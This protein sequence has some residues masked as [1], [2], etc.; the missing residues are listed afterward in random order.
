[1]RFLAVV[2]SCDRGKTKPTPSTIDVDYVSKIE[3]VN[4]NGTKCLDPFHIAIAVF[5]VGNMFFYYLTLIILG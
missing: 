4:P 1:M 5:L 2:T 3:G